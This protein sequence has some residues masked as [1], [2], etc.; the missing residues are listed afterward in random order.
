M[1]IYL[2]EQ[3]EFITTDE[4]RIILQTESDGQSKSNVYGPENPPPI[5]DDN[6]PRYIEIDWVL[7]AHKYTIAFELVCHC[8]ELCG[9]R[10]ETVIFSLNF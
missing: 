6:F 1:I 5:P 2:V 9:L 8:L 4:A 7:K 3:N 10:K